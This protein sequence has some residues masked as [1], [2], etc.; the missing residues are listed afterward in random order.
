MD[1]KISKIYENI[2]NQE[3]NN[4][5]Y[6]DNKFSSRLTILISIVAA[7]TIIF[8]TS[9]FGNDIPRIKRYYEMIILVVCVLTILLNIVLLISFYKVFFRFKKTYRV[10][11]TV[12]IRMFHFYIHK[13]HLLGTEDEKDLYNYLVDS[14]QFC[15][16]ENAK[17][18][19]IRESALIIYDNVATLCFLLCL[20]EYIFMKTQGYSIDWI[21]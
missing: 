21:F 9:F 20:F 11:P 1:E 6:L 14:Y 10:M 19:T 13:N 15:S 4:R 7:T 3:L 2:Y 8:V 17:I 5:Y 18:N 12:D 16:F